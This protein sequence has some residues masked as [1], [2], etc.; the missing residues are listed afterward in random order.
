[1]MP[2]NNTKHVQPYLG[3]VS[4]IVLKVKTCNIVRLKNGDRRIENASW[5][6]F[7]VLNHTWMQF[8][9]IVDDEQVY[10]VLDQEPKNKIA[11]W[12]VSQEQASVCMFPSCL[13]CTS[14][15]E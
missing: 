8:D 9:F 3:Y 7:V 2:K 14:I 10:R 11:V 1:M 4:R 5:R 13:L 12:T 15:S 6:G